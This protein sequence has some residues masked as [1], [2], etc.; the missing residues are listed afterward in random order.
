[1]VGPNDVADLQTKVHDYRASLQA[2]IDQAAGTPVAVPLQGPFSIAQWGD[3]VGRCVSF[4]TEST[5]WVNPL[6]LFYAGSAY[7]RGRELIA[8]LDKWRDELERRKVPNVPLPLPVPYS[9]IGLGSALGIGLGL[10]AAILLLH[11]LKR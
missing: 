2:V 6:N 1:M 4:E 8:E 7:D 3:L 9:D 11:E 5:S 10:V